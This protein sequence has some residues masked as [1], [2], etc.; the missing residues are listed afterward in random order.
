MNIPE[1]ASGDWSIEHFEVTEDGARFHNLRAAFRPGH[2]TIRPGRYTALKR[3]G[4]VIMSD[5]PAEIRDHGFFIHK[6]SGR[7]LING[8]G[9]GY[10]TTKVLEK[11]SVTEVTVIEKSPDVIALVAPHISDARL[12]VVEADALS[13]RPPVGVRYDA[14][15]H[16]IWDDICADNLEQMKLLHR[17]YGRRC[18]WQGSWARSLCERQAA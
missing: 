10:C 11:P 18:D 12:T 9:L 7:V 1:G 15:W 13:W 14:V 8:L 16:D 4:R 3:S 2:R 6:A 5:V 17:R